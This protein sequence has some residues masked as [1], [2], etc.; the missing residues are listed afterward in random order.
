MM[1]KIIEVFVELRNGRNEKDEIKKTTGRP[2]SRINFSRSREL[3]KLVFFPSLFSVREL[4]LGGD[5]PI[6]RQESC[7]CSLEY[8]WLLSLW[9]TFYLLLFWHTHCTSASCCLKLG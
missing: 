6:W 5:A 4:E 2:P 1:M 3:L 9:Y 7:S 8:H